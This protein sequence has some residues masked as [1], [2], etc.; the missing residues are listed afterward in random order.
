MLGD[1]QKYVRCYKMI[2]K[3]LLFSIACM[4]RKLENDIAKLLLLHRNLF[5]KTSAVFLQPRYTGRFFLLLYCAKF[6]S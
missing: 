3:I 6:L 2:T 5:K 1:T 4:D